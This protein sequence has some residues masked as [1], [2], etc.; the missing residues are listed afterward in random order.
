MA[1]GSD[2]LQQGMPPTAIVR[3]GCPDKLEQNR[4]HVTFE[5]GIEIRPAHHRCATVGMRMQRGGERMVKICT[6]A[7]KVQTDPI[8]QQHVITGGREARSATKQDGYR[9]SKPL[10][11]GRGSER[12]QRGACELVARKSGA[13]KRPCAQFACKQCSEPPRRACVGKGAHRARDRLELIELER[14]NATAR[15]DEHAQA[16]CAGCAADIGLEMGAARTGRAIGKEA[17]VA[18]PAT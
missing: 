15:V 16:A 4:I 3:L 1:D 8:A 2:A 5:V 11:H 6:T 12:R 14:N 7:N 9:G 18:R 17:L 13:I 10:A